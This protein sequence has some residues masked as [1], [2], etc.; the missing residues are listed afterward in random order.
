MVLTTRRILVLRQSNIPIDIGLLRT[1]TGLQVAINNYP[2][3]EG[4]AIFDCGREINWDWP[5][6]TFR[7][8]V[9]D[10]GRN[11]I[12]TEIGP[13]DDVTGILIDAFNTEEEGAVET[14]EEEA[15]FPEQ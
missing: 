7:V 12:D 9:C 2:V 4:Y 8:G 3:P 11:H 5:D 10:V 6:K 13:K 15:G 14:P 1:Q